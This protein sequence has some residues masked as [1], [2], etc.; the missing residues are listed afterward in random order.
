MTMSLVVNCAL[1]ILAA[2]LLVAGSAKLLAR[3]ESISWPYVDGLLAAPRGPRL[4]GAGE[5][6]AAVAVVLLPSRLGC[7]VAALAYGA[8]TLAAQRLRGQQCACFGVA[9]LAAVG[10][11]HV[12]ANAAGALAAAALAPIAGASALAPRGIGLV[13]A[14]TAL[15][16]LL[17]HLDRRAAAPDGGPACTEPVRSV[18]VYVSESCPSCRS[19]SSLLERMEDTRRTLVNT[20]VVREKESLPKALQVLGVPSAIGLSSAGHVIC[21]PVSGI[22]NVKALVDQVVIGLDDLAY[23]R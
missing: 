5:C 10:R 13:L 6:A 17:W 22:G 21:S 20:V 4:V 1:G 7:A 2:P 15:V 14:A 19:L 16:S 23:V 3:A 12:A 11:G 9:R 8:L 18:R